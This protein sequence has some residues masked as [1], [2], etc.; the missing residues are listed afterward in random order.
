LD[1]NLLVDQEIST[2]NARISSAEN[3]FTDFANL[4]SS[5]SSIKEKLDQSKDQAS[6]NNYIVAYKL[7]LDSLA[8]LLQLNSQ[9]LANLIAIKDI[10]LHNVSNS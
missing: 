6:Y 8:Q 4:I 2:L 10:S 3:I 5:I 7:L 9:I 1:T